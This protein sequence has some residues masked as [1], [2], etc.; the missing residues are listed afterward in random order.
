MTPVQPA[1]APATARRGR[2]PSHGEPVVDRALAVLAAFADG[3]RELT[4]S[5][6]G[7][8][9]ALPLSTARRLAERL[10]AW[11]AL[12]RGADGRYVV[13]LRLWE[14]ASLAPRTLGL[15]EVAMPYLD[16]LYEATRQHVLL[17]VLDGD[18]A[19]L[20][21]RRSARTAVPVQYRVGDRLPLHMTAV[22]RLLLAFAPADLQER[23]LAGEVAGRSD[24]PPPQPAALR[25]ALA[26]IRRTGVGVIDRRRP[27]PVVSVAA[28]VRGPREEV[29]A[30]LS[31]VVP[32]GRASAAALEPA[33]RAAARAVSRGLGAPTATAPG[34]ETSA[35][36]SR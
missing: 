8:R 13:G 20:V 26:E 33:V 31:I 15:R 5:D 18:A 16:D 4:L 34:P 30:A 9:A 32:A 2:R 36:R 25:R 17:A 29:V 3:H 1:P 14:V 22:G 28:P 27:A 21:E 23:V 7:R 6:L 35:A 12:E 24:D 11:G 10:V 19:L